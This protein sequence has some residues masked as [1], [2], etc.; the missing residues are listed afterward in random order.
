[1]KAD[2]IMFSFRMDF[3]ELLE[4]VRKMDLPEGKYA[5][6]GSGPIAIRRLRPGRDVDIIV[7]EDV[8]ED[9]AKSAG[10]NHKRGYG[11]EFLERGGIELWKGIGPGDWD[12][13][14]MIDRSDIIECLAFVCLE[15]F[16]AWKTAAGRD[17]DLRD[18]EL[19]KK[20][21]EENQ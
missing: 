5:I 19:A 9:Y 4:E 8:Y 2:N 18:V 10:W 7:N 1:M 3:F 15:D 14:R 20:W 16:I 21:L 6:L 13:Q 12:I 17:K 11:R